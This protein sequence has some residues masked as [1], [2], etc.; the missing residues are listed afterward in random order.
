VR[1]APGTLRPAGLL[2][3]FR[4]EVALLLLETLAELEPNE[5]AHERLVEEIDLLHP[6]RDLTLGDLREDLLRLVRVLRIF[7]RLR[8]ENGLLLLDGVGRNLFLANELRS[9]RRDL[10]RD[11]LREIQSARRRR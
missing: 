7:L 6:L 5:A 3:D 11:V 2:R 9:H 8:D 1:C 10:H 4:G